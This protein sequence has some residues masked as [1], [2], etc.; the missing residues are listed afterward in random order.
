MERGSGTSL[1]LTPNA[2]LLR[3]SP[4]LSVAPILAA[5]DQEISLLN[6]VR[7][8]LTG[9]GVGKRIAPSAGKGTSSKKMGKH[10]RT[11]SPEGRERIAAAQRA[12]WAAKKKAAK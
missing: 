5:I 8:L 6:K 2:T 11:L 3:M 4:S 1:T 10:K 12:R 7:A 9:G